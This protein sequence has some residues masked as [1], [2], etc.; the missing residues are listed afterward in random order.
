MIIARHVFLANYLKIYESKQQYA[1]LAVATPQEQLK[2][3]SQRQ[4]QLNRFLAF[5]LVI[6]I[7]IIN[8]ICR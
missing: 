7:I 4:R 6:I 8:I 5:V 3:R 1:V 2:I